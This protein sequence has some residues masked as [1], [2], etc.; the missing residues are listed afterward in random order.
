LLPCPYASG[1]EFEALEG[2]PAN[3]LFHGSSWDALK[4]FSRPVHYDAVLQLG[5]DLLFGRWLAWR[6]K[7]PLLCYSYGLK[8]GMK[9]CC[10]VLTSR[11]GLFSCENLEVVG[12]LVLDSIDPAEESCWNA[13]KGKR[14]AVFPGS[15]PNIRHKVFSLLQDI[16]RGLRKRDPLVELRVLLS[17]FAEPSES[18]LWRQAGFGIWTGDTPAG[19]AGADLAVT[20]PGTN[21]LELMY[22]K[23]PFIV[24]IPFSFL[25]EMP[26][27]GLIGMIDKIPWFGAA[28]REKIIRAKIPQYIGKTSW[29]NRLARQSVV[30]ELVGEYT[31][32]QIAQ[33]VIDLLSDRE[34]LQRQKIKLDELASQ[35]APGA[36]ERICRI[37]EG[38]TAV[39]G[40]E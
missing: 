3:V 24:L 5:G 11:R 8:K 27:S 22:C 7:A 2:L 21:N 29:P 40:T 30:P 35:V 33:A 14:I 16:R 18:A 15:R 4:S 38:V 32:D 28:L 17:P 23:M 19:I 13:P 36:P 6:Q 9:H 34:A 37:L 12:D 1:R 25:R 20:Q 39:N 26:L 31:G 10:K